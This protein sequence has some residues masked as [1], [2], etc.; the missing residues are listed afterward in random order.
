MSSK[1]EPGPNDVLMGRGATTNTATGNVRF[2]AV[3]AEHQPQY[4]EAKKEEK[5]GIARIIV[6]TV[7]KRGGKFLMK[8]ENGEY[9]EVDEKKALLKAQQALREGLNVRKSPEVK[10]KKGIKLPS[11]A[12]K[13]P[14]AAAA[15][16]QPIAPRPLTATLAPA[17][18]HTKPS[19]KIQGDDAQVGGL[20]NDDVLCGRGGGTN[21]YVGNIRFRAVVA[22]HQPRYLVCRRA[23]KEVIAAEIVQ[24]IHQRGGRFLSKNEA[25]QW[26]EVTE[27]KA[28]N[29]ASQALREGMNVR[30][31][32]L[33]SPERESKFASALSK[34]KSQQ[35]V[36]VKEDA[37]SLIAKL[38]TMPRSQLEAVARALLC[39]G[40]NDAVSV[41]ISAM[42]G[43]SA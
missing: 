2:R 6:E 19:P 22:Q 41:A 13:P 40:S 12:S 34:T 17:S 25:G 38:P 33:K 36:V 10:N 37:N 42:N 32:T 21:A 3:V 4:L 11:T 39:S 14:P 23:D 5:E 28:I 18:I 43:A 15:A 8:N 24:I 26:E 20:K 9:T 7:H 35:A 1:E 31:G 27:K 29:K 30:G 16:S